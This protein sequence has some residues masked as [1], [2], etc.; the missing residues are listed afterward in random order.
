M[1]RDG[2]RQVLKLSTRA[3]YARGLHRVGYHVIPHPIQRSCTYARGLHRSGIRDTSPAANAKEANRKRAETQVGVPK[4]V[5][6]ERRVS[7]D[8]QRSDSRDN[9]ERVSV[10][11]A[12]GVGEATAGLGAQGE[13]VVDAL[14]IGLERARTRPG[15]I[16]A[17]GRL[18]R[19]FFRPSHAPE[20]KTAGA[21]GPGRR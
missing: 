8:T 5:A 21:R 13:H 11:E 3:T 20:K 17:F 10:A 14:R 19:R 1:R 9:W 15:Y 7:R 16:V 4:E 18:T 2:K 12:T 6:R